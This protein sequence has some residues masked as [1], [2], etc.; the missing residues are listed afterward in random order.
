MIIYRLLALTLLI[1]SVSCWAFDFSTKDKVFMQGG[2]CADEPFTIF[3]AS[4]T[5][6][7]GHPNV[8]FFAFSE[9]CVVI[10]EAE[11]TSFAP[12]SFICH[13]GGKTVLSGATYKKVRTDFINDADVY[14][15]ECMKG[16]EHSPKKIRYSVGNCG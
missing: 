16:C 2:V 8:D 14:T 4:A 13:P 6:K 3:Q 9:E 7:A 1:S 12:I 5:I 11:P 10:E 15:Y